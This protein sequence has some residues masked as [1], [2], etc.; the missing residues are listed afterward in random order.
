MA[1]PTVSWSE[2]TPAGSDNIALGD[3]R[4]RELKTQLREVIAVDHDMDS[5]GQ[6]AAWGQ[7]KKVTFQE[8]VDI[9]SGATGVPIL[10][11][12]TVSGTPVLM[13]TTE[14]DVDIQITNTTGINA[15]AITGVY[16]AANVAAMATMMSLIYPIGSVVTLGVSTNPATLFGIGTWTAIT[17][18]VI[19]GK[20][21]AG[22]FDT[23]NATGGAET[24]TLT[25]AQSGVPA[26]THGTPAG[27]AG[28]GA[29]A[30]SQ[31][32]TSGATQYGANGTSA[33]N[34][35]ADAASAHTNLQPYIVKYVWERTA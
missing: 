34:A 15:P 23:L 21:A 13:Y 24:V 35:T 1:V 14:A 29:Y 32:W 12:Q 22:T 20:A 10:G 6:D 25:S 19:V 31:A 28:G 11:A 26:H 17:G 8:A 18:S 9:G 30:G 33:A 7:H 2:T 3:N 5:T 16:A 27:Q 4:I